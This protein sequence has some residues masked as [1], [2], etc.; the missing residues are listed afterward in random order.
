[1]TVPGAIWKACSEAL[2]TAICGPILTAVGDVSCRSIWR[3]TG[4]AVRTAIRHPTCRATGKPV[5]M[6][7]RRWTAGAVC[8]GT[9]DAT[10]GPTIEVTCNVRVRIMPERKAAAFAAAI[11]G[12]G[13][14]EAAHVGAVF[15]GLHTGRTGLEF[16][17][18]V[19]VVLELGVFADVVRAGLGLV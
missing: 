17:V 15:G 6:A 19:L 12:S 13:P 5:V 10:C 3:E 8:G 9:S 1:M 7:T 14:L 11:Q 16:V 4:K 18:A 2:L